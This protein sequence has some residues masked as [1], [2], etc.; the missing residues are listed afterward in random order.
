VHPRSRRAKLSCV[1]LC[2][3]VR[4]AIEADE[5]KWMVPGGS[6]ARQEQQETAR[7]SPPGAATLGHANST[8]LGRGPQRLRRCCGCGL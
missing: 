3:A 5:S 1:P 2:C 7:A 4:A 8:R 6:R